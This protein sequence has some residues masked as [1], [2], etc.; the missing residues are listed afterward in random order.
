MSQVATTETAP[1][2]PRPMPEVPGVRHEY[3][4]AGD[5][6]LH[7]AEAGEGPPLL[8][9]HGWWQH[10]YTWHHL[11]PPLSREY[12][13]LCPDLRG[14]G[15]SEAPAQ[16]YERE[17][18]ARDVLALLDDLGIERVRVA[19]HDWGGWLG[20]LLCLMAPERVE[21]FM[22]LGIANPSAPLSVASIANYWRFWYQYVL[23][24]PLIGAAAVRRLSQQRG[25]ILRWAAGARE[26]RNEQELGIFLP[27]LQEPARVRASVLLYRDF[28]RRDMRRMLVGRYRRDRPGVPTLMLHGSDDK[29]IRPSNLPHPKA[30]AADLEIELIP[31]C[32]HF[33]IDERPELV[34]ERARTFFGP[35]SNE[36]TRC[37][38]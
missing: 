14:F 25:L 10:W 26:R 9:L 37:R 12:R 17:T 30:W 15:W 2:S 21:R 32:G 24:A 35:A 34:L 33:I 11:I 4:Q 31:D 18:M 7:L 38:Q 6:L 5:V 22:A 28:L 23:A 29:I 19:G 16:G 20:F 3:R 1:K 27:Q 8:L 36:S 13:V